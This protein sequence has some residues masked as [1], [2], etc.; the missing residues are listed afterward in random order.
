MAMTIQ[1][2]MMYCIVA[3]NVTNNH[4]VLLVVVV[5]SS[6]SMARGGVVFDLQSTPRFDDS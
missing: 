1:A 6:R 2:Y 3:S 5:V 4:H